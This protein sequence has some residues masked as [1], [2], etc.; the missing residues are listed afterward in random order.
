M[1]P[2]MCVFVCVRATVKS[3]DSANPKAASMRATYIRN[4]MKALAITQPAKVCPYTRATP[5]H[6]H[7]PHLSSKHNSKAPAAVSG[8]ADVF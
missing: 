1:L 4:H 3:I 6:R 8:V 7:M 5:Y 2:L